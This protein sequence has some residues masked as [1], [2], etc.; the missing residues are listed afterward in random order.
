MALLQSHNDYNILIQFHNN[1]MVLKEDLKYYFIKWLIKIVITIFY[2]NNRKNYR[3]RT[4]E[5]MVL[6][7]I[8]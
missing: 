6:P 7:G 8:L 1:T 2:D 5:A 4:L 3:I